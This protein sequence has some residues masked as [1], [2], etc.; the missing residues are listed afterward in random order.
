MEHH[1]HADAAMEDAPL[2]SGLAE[3]VDATEIE[4][5]L[6]N[7][8]IGGCN[9]A[10]PTF[11]SSDDDEDEEGEEHQGNARMSDDLS[12]GGVGSAR[13]SHG[14]DSSPAECSRRGNEEQ[15]AEME[16]DKAVDLLAHDVDPYK[17]AMHEDSD[18]GFHAFLPSKPQS[19]NSNIPHGEVCIHFSCLFNFKSVLYFLVNK[20][21]L[22]LPSVS[23]VFL[24]WIVS[25]TDIVSVSKMW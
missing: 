6:W 10:L 8:S 22:P 9:D 25:M 2:G 23:V 5:A 3:S 7:A 16:G 21:C 4:C 24:I 15:H 18:G 12:F 20:F 19:V 17:D 13:A 11:H 14:S 1:S